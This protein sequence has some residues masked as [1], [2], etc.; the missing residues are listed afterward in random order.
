MRGTYWVPIE[1]L[2]SDLLSTSPL[3]G[4]VDPDH[5]GTSRRDGMQQ[6]S[7][8]NTSAMQGRPLG[9]TQHAVI[10][11]AVPVITLLHDA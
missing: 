5:H 11:L 4:L 6:P 7:Q 10:V 3:D 1:P 9:P 8:Q 2:S